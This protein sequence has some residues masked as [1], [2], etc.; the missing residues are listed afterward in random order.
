[1]SFSPRLGLL[2]ELVYVN[3][4]LVAVDPPDPSPADLDRWQIARTD[5]GVD[6]GHAHVEVS[7]DLLIVLMTSAL[8]VAI[9][10][11]AREKLIDI[12]SAA[13]SAVCGSLG[14]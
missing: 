2:M 6:L 1:M 8:V 5:Q 12:V 11:V 4:E 9:W 13:L 10:G 14:C 7:R 3:L